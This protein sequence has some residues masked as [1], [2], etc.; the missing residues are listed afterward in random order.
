MTMQYVSTRSPSAMGSFTDILLEGLAHDGGLAVPVAIPQ[1]SSET[2][3]SLSRLAYPELA[4]KV[5][6]AFADDLG[7][8]TLRPL[9]ARAYTA[10]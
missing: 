7:L 6:H 8:E 3:Q 10:E 9:T 4:A 1:W 5:V 2:I